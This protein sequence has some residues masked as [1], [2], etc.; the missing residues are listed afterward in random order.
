MDS[1]LIAPCGINCGTC[2]AYLRDKNRCEGCIVDSQN[3]KAKC[4]IRNC[5]ERKGNGC[6]DCKSF[7]CLR[8]K[9]IDKR[10]TEKYNLSLIKNLEMIKEIGI[11][12]FM[13]LEEIKW[14]CK[15]CNGT[16]C[17]H[18]GFCLKCGE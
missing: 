4:K 15:M 8:I 17:V 9:K 6:I 11:K 16:I 1:K 7:P 18:R 14:K 3:H 10:Y 5:E 13:E 2:M 12:K